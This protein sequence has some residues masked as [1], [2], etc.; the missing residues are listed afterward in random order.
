VRALALILGTIGD[1]YLEIEKLV[2]YEFDLITL[3]PNNL[4]LSR[5]FTKKA[6]NIEDQSEVLFLHFINIIQDF[7]DDDFDVRNWFDQV[8][9]HNLKSLSALTTEQ[10][11]QQWR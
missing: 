3:L 2:S 7:D 10:L 5:I 8:Y 11:Q 6:I 1:V 9:V 4:G